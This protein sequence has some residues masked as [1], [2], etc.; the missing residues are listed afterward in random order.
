MGSEE[1]ITYVEIYSRYLIFI[2]YSNPWMPR[3]PS[4]FPLG[5]KKKNKVFKERIGVKEDAQYP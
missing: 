4:F 5:E 2:N 1:F 3:S